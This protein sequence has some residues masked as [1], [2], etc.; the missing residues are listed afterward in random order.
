MGLFDLFGW[1]LFFAVLSV[2]VCVL[3]CF[4]GCNRHSIDTVNRNYALE[5]QQRA[6]ER[7]IRWYKRLEA[8]TLDDMKKQAYTDR[9]KL[10]QAK[11]RD[12][13]NENSDVLRRDLWRERLVPGFTETSDDGIIKD[14]IPKPQPVTKWSIRYLKS[15]FSGVLDINGVKKLKTAHQELLQAVMNEPLGTEYAR[16]FD[17]NMNPLGDYIKGLAGQNTVKIP[18]HNVPYI[19]IHNHPSDEML[20]ETDIRE[21]L[22]KDNLIVLTAVGNKGSVYAVEKGNN[23][24]RVAAKSVYSKWTINNPTRFKDFLSYESAMESLLKELKHHG[25][26][27]YT[28]RN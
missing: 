2:L 8:G 6:L 11:L 18:M 5:Q 19:V 13:I 16:A 24:N 4:R 25:I 7:E 21:F 10:A 22:E 12:F 27:Y 20:S 9:R 26:Y 23:F 1:L 15:Y 3:W 28:A 14:T 17:I